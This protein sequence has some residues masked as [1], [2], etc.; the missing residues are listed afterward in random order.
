[1]C[2][3]SCSVLSNSAIPVDCSPP[4]S[5]C[6]WGFSRQEYWSG[7]LCPPAGDLPNPG[8]KFMSLVSPALAG[9]FFTTTTIWEAHRHSIQFPKR[10]KF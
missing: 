3:L 10:I 7:L 4:D 1:M 8:I 6:P 2:V 5:L 9:G